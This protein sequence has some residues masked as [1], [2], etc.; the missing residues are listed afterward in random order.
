MWPEIVRRA[1]NLSSI[2]SCWVWKGRGWGVGA[3]LG[4]FL[5][6]LLLFR[7]T[8]RFLLGGSF[9]AFLE[10]GLSEEE[11]EAEGLFL[12]VPEGEIEEVFTLPEEEFH[13]LKQ[14][15]APFDRDGNRKS[16]FKQSTYLPRPAAGWTGFQTNC[17]IVVSWV[18][19]I[20]ACSVIVN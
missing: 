19:S 20:A 3:L 15:L 17:G 12:F 14:N 6:K 18:C 11:E 2:S 8:F 16:S 1:A 13:R 4:L 10:V 9:L 5:V 7:G